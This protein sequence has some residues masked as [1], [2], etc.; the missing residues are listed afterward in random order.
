MVDVVTFG[1]QSASPKRDE[2]L[3]PGTLVAGHVSGGPWVG[4][5]CR[6]ERGGDDYY[7][8][9]TGPEKLQLRGLYQ[10]DPPTIIP[11]RLLIE[12]LPGDLAF[13]LPFAAADAPVALLMTAEG[14]PHLRIGVEFSPGRREY[15]IIE[16]ASGLE[17]PSVR[18]RI[19]LN[20]F[21]LMV[22]QEGREDPLELAR[23]D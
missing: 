14:Q 15:V 9:L 8:M 20:R 1:I 18:S 7:L 4:L 6:D 5:A 10:V 23:F 22:K 11:G 17:A 13:Q 12:P 16:I 21:R 3:P 19:L 2:P